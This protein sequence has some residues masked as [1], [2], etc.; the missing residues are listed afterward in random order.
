MYGNAVY[1]TR[2]S[3]GKRGKLHE[4]VKCSYSHH[5]TTEKDSD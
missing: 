1:N 3:S 2:G 4:G 5:K